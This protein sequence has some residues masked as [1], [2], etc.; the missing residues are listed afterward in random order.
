MESWLEVVELGC[1]G[2]DLIKEVR[3]QKMGLR[4]CKH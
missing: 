4:Q 2:R 1:V 3:E